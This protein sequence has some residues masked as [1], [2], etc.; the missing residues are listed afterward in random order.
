MKRSFV[1]FVCAFDLINERQYIYTFE[2]RCVENSMLG[3]GNDTTKI[4]VH[5]KGTMDDITPEMKRLLDFID[6]KEPES[7]LARELDEEV[8][9]E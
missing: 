4:I 2:N 1:V 7:D 5:T 6:G 9:Y 3:L 8:Q